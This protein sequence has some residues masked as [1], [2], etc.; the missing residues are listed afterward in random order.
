MLGTADSRYVFCGQGTRSEAQRS[1]SM[2]AVIAAQLL[3]VIY[4]VLGRSCLELF[5]LCKV[6]GF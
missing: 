5:V 6:N 3:C 1:T 4:T 2:C